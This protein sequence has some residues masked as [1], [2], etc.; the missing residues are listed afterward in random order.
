MAV[1]LDVPHGAVGAEDAELG[2]V[3][4]DLAGDHPADPFLDRGD[5]VGM[6][7]GPPAGAGPVEFRAREA[8]EFEH[9]VVPSEAVGRDVEFPDSVV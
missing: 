3:G 4:G 8:V 7:A 5:V 9:A 1:G 6:E 2:V